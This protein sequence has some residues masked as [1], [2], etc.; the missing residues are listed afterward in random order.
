MSLR[1]DHWELA[2]E[3]LLNGNKVPLAALAGFLLR[4]F[5]FEGYD[6]APDNDDLGA[7]F[8]L[9]FAY[10]DGTGPAELD[11]LYDTTFEAA[12]DWFEEWH[13]G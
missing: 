5:A 12:P 1:D 11:Y 4:D 2:R 9:M 10:T 7:A 6:P 13:G 3:H 8:V